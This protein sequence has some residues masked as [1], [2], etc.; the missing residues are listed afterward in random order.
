MSRLTQNAFGATVGISAPAVSDLVKRNILDLRRGVDQ[1]ILDYCAHIREKAAG[2][3]GAGDFDLTEERARLAHHQANIAALD[4][5][6]KEKHL[7]P[8]EVVLSR[9]VDIAANV[10][11]RLLSIPPQ[12]A[13]TCVNLPREEIE[14]RAVDLIRTALEELANEP[15]Y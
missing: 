14:K 12:L 2:R 13:A 9:W 3:S 6:V 5:K 1:S 10:R 8:S 15:Q 4:E 7:I 11:A